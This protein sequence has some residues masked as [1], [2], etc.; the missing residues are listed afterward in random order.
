MSAFSNMTNRMSAKPDLNVNINER[1][2]RLNDDDGEGDNSSFW[3]N[4]VGWIL[5]RSK[6]NDFLSQQLDVMLDRSLPERLVSMVDNGN[7][8][9]IISNERTDCIKQ[10][11]CKTAPFIWG[12]QKAVT[13]QMNNSNADITETDES[14]KI[15]E[16]TATV[17]DD[18]D[19][20]TSIF[21]KYLPT[22]DEFKDHGITCEDLY[23]QCKLF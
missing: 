6:S 5:E 12:M 3:E 19:E 21:F 7:N 15:N 14:A 11:L 1:N 23:K 13:S 18:V 2:R 20:R 9:E 4:T 16:K 22:T 10:L 17:D 8:D